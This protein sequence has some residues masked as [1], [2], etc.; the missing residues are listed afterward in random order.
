[1]NAFADQHALITGGGSGIGA[2]IAK[3]MTG[4]GARVTLMGRDAGKLQDKAKE[5]GA[6]SHR[7]Q[8]GSNGI[9]CSGKAEWHSHD[10]RQ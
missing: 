10:P 1:L 9:C 4:A 6:A 3:A 8:P 2:A 5:L 7:S